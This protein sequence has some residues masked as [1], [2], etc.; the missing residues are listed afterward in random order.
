V[1]RM[2]NLLEIGGRLLVQS[3]LVAESFLPA[4]Q[5][6]TWLAVGTDIQVLMENYYDPCTAQLTQQ[7]TYYQQTSGGVEMAQR[8]AEY[9]LYTIAELTRFLQQA[10][11]T[12]LSVYGTL[13]G[14]PYQIGDDGVWLVCE[15]VK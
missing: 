13:D 8:K 2:A 9:T 4:F 10:G 3:S 1:Q 6:R 5:E 14:N 11:F 12:I 7:L 15:R